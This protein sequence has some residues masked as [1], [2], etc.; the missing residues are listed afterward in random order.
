MAEV[1]IPPVIPDGQPNFPEMGNAFTTLST[2][3]QRLGNIPGV[4]GH[5]GITQALQQLTNQMNQLSNQ[6]NQRFN[7]M[8]SRFIDIQQTL[9][10][11]ERGRKAM[12]A[13]RI[14]IQQN[15]HRADTNVELIPL[16]SHLTN[17]IPADFPLRLSDV[18]QMPGKFAQCTCASTNP[19]S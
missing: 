19:N 14:P 6:M 11:S 13:N 12:V 7:Q 1:P 5:L 3:M 10:S 8:D 18:T 4:Q 9:N 2:N 16:Q 17:E 15:K